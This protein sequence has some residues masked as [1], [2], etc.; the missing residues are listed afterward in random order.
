M[1]KHPLGGVI[2]TYQKYDPKLFPSPTTPP[3]RMSPAFEF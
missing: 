2:H 3:D 1:A